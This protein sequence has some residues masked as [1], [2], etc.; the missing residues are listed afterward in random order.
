M[1]TITGPNLRINQALF[2]SLGFLF[3]LCAMLPLGLQADAPLMPNLVFALAI[4]WTIRRPASA[5]WGS[6]FA[7]ALLADVLLMKPIGLWAAL[8]LGLSEFARA[9]RWAIRE[10]MFL[11][12]WAIFAAVFAFALALN[13][14]LLALVF[15][16]RPA[17]PLVL[18][19]FLS[20]TLA[21]PVVVLL[22]HWVFGVRSPRVAHQSKRLSRIS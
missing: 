5:P 6:I 10:Q 21:Y 8:T 15:E 18:N 2:F 7:L 22:I 17:L 12:E 3:I 11:V 20:T 13:A 1:A 19:Y 9:Q 4:S 14:L 16:P